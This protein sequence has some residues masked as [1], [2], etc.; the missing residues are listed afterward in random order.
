MKKEIFYETYPLPGFVLLFVLFLVPV[1]LTLGQAFIVDS[2]F[3]FS[4]LCS[5]FKDAY[6]LRIMAFTL[7][8]ALC[9]TFLSLLIGLPGAYFMT[10]YKFPGKK[11]L[12]ALY[13]VPFV[14]PSILVVLGFVIFYGNSGFLNKAL[15]SIFKLQNPPIKILYSFASVLLAHSFYNFPVVTS[16]VGNYWQKMDSSCESAATTLGSGKFKVFCTVT[17]P[18]LVPAIL[19]ASSLVFLF[20]FTSFAIILVLG[21][22]PSLTTVEVEIYRLA[23]ISMNAQKACALSLFSMLIAIVV[24]L[25][26]SIAQKQQNHGEQLA[27]SVSRVEKN[28]CGFFQ[29]FTLIVYIVL[30]LLFILCPILSIVARSFLGS[31]TRSSSLVFSTAAYAKLFAKGTT[32]L[33]AVLT[34]LAVAVISSVLATVI[35]LRI[36]THIVNAKKTGIIGDIVVMLPMVTSSVI[37]GLSYF[38][39]SKYLKFI[40]P[41]ILVV[42]SHCVITMPFVVRTILPVYRK[43]PVNLANAS[44]TMGYNERETFSK[45]IKP[46]LKPAMI[47]GTVFSFA[48]SMGELNATLLLGSGS[49]QTIPMQ[50][51]RLIG[52]YNY[53]GACA[54]GVVLIIVCCIVF[55]ISETLKRRSYV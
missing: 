37:V 33:N 2:H 13:K 40:P 39:V 26:Y 29:N 51:Y 53:Q 7:F 16:I 24:M 46:I 14:L 31:A 49:I 17:L 21:G 12:N 50:I 11:I 41:Y 23:R 22:G 25:M 1:S 4:L 44:R 20:C 3:S 36:C 19:S 15:M 48:M 55:F 5:T 47:T 30:S 28:P 35:A 54:L 18:R 43:I 8:Q 6:Y 10:V 45:I 52:A 34:S 32:S 9:S 38:V 27:G 42:L